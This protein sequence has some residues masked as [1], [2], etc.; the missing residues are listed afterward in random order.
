M[1]TPK[2]HTLTPE[3]KLFLM[4]TH[5]SI[6]FQESFYKVMEQSLRQNLN[7]CAGYWLL[8][9]TPSQL[10]DAVLV[11]TGKAEV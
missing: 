9:A 10:A 2:L 6:D 7:H 11:A 8:K 3:Q 4:T 1:T 5:Q